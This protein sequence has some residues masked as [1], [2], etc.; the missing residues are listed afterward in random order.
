MS[1]K[2]FERTM[3]RRFI[4]KRKKVV[5]NF[6]IFNCLTHH[7]NDFLIF[8]SLYSANS[9]S[10]DQLPFGWE[11]RQDANGR[12][13]YVNHVARSTQWERPTVT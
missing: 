8:Q 4:F 10:Q 12:T 11:E 3:P 7:F 6:V 9:S 5:R 13:Y 1:Q 2:A